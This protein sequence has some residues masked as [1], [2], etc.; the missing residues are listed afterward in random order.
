MEKRTTNF[1]SSIVFGFWLEW[2]FHVRENMMREVV[3]HA[4]AS[5]HATFNTWRA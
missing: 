1:S 5:N 3:E 2:D 4:K